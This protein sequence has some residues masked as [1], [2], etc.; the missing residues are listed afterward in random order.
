MKK[1]FKP[2]EKEEA[3]YFSDFSGKSFGEFNPPVE[4][5]MSFNYGSKYDGTEITIDL[6]D[7]E[8]QPVLNLLKQ[9]ISEDFKQTI[10]KRLEKLDEDFEIS[11]QMRDWDSCDKMADNLLFWRDF[12]GITGK[13]S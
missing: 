7:E 3:I 6:D 13:F 8:I 11:I 1:I 4:L 10:K 9:S 12:L 2:A 5:K